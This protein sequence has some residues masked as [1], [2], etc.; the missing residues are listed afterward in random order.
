VVLTCAGAVL[1]LSL[2]IRQSFGLFL[3]PISMDRGWSRETVAFALALQNLIWGLAQ[4]FA[5]ALADRYGAAKVLVAGG[6]AYSGGLVLMALAESPLGFGI[7]AGAL[8]G[9]GQS[10]AGFGVVLGAVGKSFP[11]KDRGVALGIVSAA[12]SIGQFVMLPGAQELIDGLGWSGALLAFAALSLAIVPLAAATARAAHLPRAADAAASDTLATALARAAAHPGFWLLSGSVF[13]C[14]FQTAFIMNHLPAYLVDCGR[15]ARDGMAALALIG[16]F[17]IA[18]NYAAGWLGN[19][20][21]KRL[22]LAAIYALRAAGI[23][24]FVALPVSAAAVWIFSAL[25]GATWLATIPLSTA[26]VAQVFG[27]RYLSTLFSIVFLGHQIG[28]FLGVWLGGAV[29]DATGSYLAMWT[30]AAALGAVAALVCL[31]INERAVPMVR[32]LRA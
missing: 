27:V 21:P 3:W 7:G 15:P 26:L 29:F 13:V 30:S 14:G 20:F 4:P 22:I 8:I 19:V 18:G 1:L 6:L 25:M 9:L 11:E 12:G 23:V 32:E 16:A 31:P 10:G 28:S 24:A 2:G 17:N 5:G